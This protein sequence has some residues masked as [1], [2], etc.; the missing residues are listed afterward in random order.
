MKVPLLI[1]ILISAVISVHLAQ[2][3]LSDFTLP[4]FRNAEL[5][6]HNYYRSLHGCPPL[7]LNDTLNKAA[8]AYAEELGKTK[9]LTHSPAAK[10]ATYGENLYKA[11]VYPK[12]AYKLGT[13]STSWYSEVQYFDFNTFKSNTAG[14]AVGHF[15]AMIWKNST[16]IGLGYVKVIENFMGYAGQAVYIVANYAPTPNLIG[17]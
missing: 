17:K 3:T 7:T 2:S 12:L 8:Q 9:T 13:A 5:D 10:K 14:K 16:Q 15:T 6:K 1:L 11:W 4:E